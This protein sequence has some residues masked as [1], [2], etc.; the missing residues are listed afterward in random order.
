M[1][2]LKIN[3]NQ[4]TV[5]VDNV[6]YVFTNSWDAFEFIYSKHVKRTREG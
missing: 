3:K 5:T 6:K 1:I 2:T 4:W